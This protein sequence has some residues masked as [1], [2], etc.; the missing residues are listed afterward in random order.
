MQLILGDWMREEMIRR[1]VFYPIKP[2]RHK[3]RGKSE[4]IDGLQP[5]IANQQVYFRRDQQDIINEAVALIIVDNKIKGNSSPNMMDALAY[6]CE[7]WHSCPEQG[8]LLDDDIRL[9]DDDDI[10]MIKRATRYGLVCPT[11]AGRAR[12]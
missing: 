7:L 10:A 11:R 3:R 5:F 9:V 1:D 4:R 12:M 6:S 2:A 8:T